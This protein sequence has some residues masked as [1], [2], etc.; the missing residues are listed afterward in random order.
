[1]NVSNQF[2]IFLPRSVVELVAKQKRYE[3]NQCED[4]QRRIFRALRDL[5]QSPSSPDGSREVP[6]CF[7]NNTHC[8]SKI[9]NKI[10]ACG[11]EV[12]ESELYTVTYIAATVTLKSVKLKH[13]GQ[14]GSTTS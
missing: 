3:E 2:S 12:E 8:Y 7:A 6:L 4:T 5:S 9:T 10:K 1:M 14:E 13:D 11:L